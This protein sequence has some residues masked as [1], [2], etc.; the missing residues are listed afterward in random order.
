MKPVAKHQVQENRNPRPRAFECR[1]QKRCDSLPVPTRKSWVP[2]DKSH[3]LG[4]TPARSIS[5]GCGVHSHHRGKDLPSEFWPEP[6][7]RGFSAPITPPREDYGSDEEDKRNGVPTR[8]SENKCRPFRASMKRR[9]EAEFQRLKQRFERLST[10][11]REWEGWYK[12]A[13]R[14]FFKTLGL[15]WAESDWAKF[16]SLENSFFDLQG[17]LFAVED[18]MERRNAQMY[19]FMKHVGPLNAGVWLRERD[20]TIWALEGAA[21]Q[22][23]RCGEYP[24]LEW[25]GVDYNATERTYENY[26]N[27][28]S[29]A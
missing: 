15:D 29:L 18:K 21:E 23:A 13:R 16:R 5:Q 11:L 4:E 20:T 7:A 27:S 28:S 14:L 8:Y 24:V 12:K 3:L 17:E 9:I 26:E 19:L 1:P 22:R 10:T 25:S 2:L 6:I